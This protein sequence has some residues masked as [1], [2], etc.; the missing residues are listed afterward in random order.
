MVFFGLFFV[1]DVPDRQ[2]LAL[3]D[4]LVG[5]SAFGA[6]V[7]GLGRVI[8][9]PATATERLRFQVVDIEDGTFE[10]GAFTDFVV[11]HTNVF[12]NDTGQCADIQRD[13]FDLFDATLRGSLISCSD[14]VL[15]DRQ[16]MHLCFPFQGVP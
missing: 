9:V 3:D 11:V 12:G 5:I 15:N 16:F 4:L 14:E 13:A 1:G 7:I 8:H 10:S 6:F 2:F